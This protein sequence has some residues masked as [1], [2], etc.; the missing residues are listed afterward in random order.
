[1]SWFRRAVEEM[2]AYVPGEQPQ[3]TQRIIKLN[4]NENPYP[5]S[6]MV[7]E[8]IAREI[9]DAGARLRLYSDPNARELREEAARL[10]GFEVEQILHGNG[11]DELLALLVRA[12]IEPGDSIAYPYPT[13]VLYETLARSEGAK[14]ESVDFDRSFALPR[15]LNGTTAKLVFVANPNSPSGTLSSVADLR[16]LARSSKQ[17]VLVVDE[18]YGDFADGSALEL[19]RSE[20]NVVVLRTF[21][22]S[23]SLAGMRLG[24][25]FGSK[26]LVS[27]IGKLKDSYNLDRLAIVAGT[28]ALRDQPWMRANVE[29][30]KR[31]RARLVAGLSAFGMDVLPSQ[32]NFVFARL[33]SADKARAAYQFLK[34]RG[35]LVRYFKLRLLDDGL[36][37][38]VGT[39]S[40][41]DELL[42][43]L[44]AFG[45]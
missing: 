32:A 14:I 27:G 31:T 34:D 10:Y 24:L 35:I 4:T 2:E 15:A 38:T 44:N 30:I 1:M 7:A 33:G 42:A 20:P 39:D 13:Y 8:A 28:A 6:P 18:A 16:E 29:K 25:L 23:Y 41:V 12:A 19:A 9:G 21:S 43:A 5:A 26:E 45:G 17:G 40:E 37:I 22:K 11:S 3:G 36:R